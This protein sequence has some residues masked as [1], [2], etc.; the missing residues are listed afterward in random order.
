[1]SDRYLKGWLTGWK[2][3]AGYISQT[4]KTAKKYHKK[5]G[6]TIRRGPGGKPIALPSELDKWLIKFDDLKKTKKG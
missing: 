3:I 6:M 4:I 1:V 5:Y 2:E